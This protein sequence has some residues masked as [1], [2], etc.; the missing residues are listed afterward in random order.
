M[1]AG[2][3]RPFDTSKPAYTVLSNMRARNIVN[4]HAY[5]VDNCLVHVADPIF[6]GF[7][8]SK[9]ADCSSKVVPKLI[10]TEAVGV[11]A[12][13]G[14]GLRRC[15][16]LRYHKGRQIDATRTNQAS[17]VPRISSITSTRL[18]RGSRRVRSHV[19]YQISEK[20]IPY[21]DL[22][23]SSACSDSAEALILANALVSNGIELEL[24]VFDVFPCEAHASLGGGAR[25]GVQHVEE[26]AGH[27]EHDLGT[28]RRDLLAQQWWYI[29]A[30]GVSIKVE[31]VEIEVSPLATYAGEGLEPI[32]GKTLTRSGYVDSIEA[33]DALV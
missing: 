29:E 3:C 19:T 17:A 5:T 31:D 15:G 21:I 16:V 1:Y 12:M 8:I 32:K 20:K 27:G 18:P 6:V 14:D 13:K 25:G 7:Y 9:P 4:I 23:S 26:R 24:F 2:F 33:F 10:V 30:T 11:V 28:S 22:S